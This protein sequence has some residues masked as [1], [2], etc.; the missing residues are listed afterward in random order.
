[1]PKSDVF[2]M[3]CLEAMRAMPDKAFDLAIV[4]P[5]YGINA[6]EMNM[7]SNPTR[8]RNDGHGS[9]PAISTAVKLKGRLN[10]GGG[11][12][13]N[14]LLNTSKFGWD[15]EKPS[16]DYWQELFRISKNQIVFGGNYF[17]EYLPSSRGVGC[18]DKLQPWENFSQW[19][20]IWTSFDCPSFIIRKSNT[21][22]ANSETK[23]HPTQKPVYVYRYLLKKF[24]VPLNSILD[25]HLGSQSSRIAAYQMGFDF[26][27]YEIDTAY[28]NDGNKRFAEATAQASLFP[29]HETKQAS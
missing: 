10:S 5:P 20:M 22:G 19:E 21:G 4:D 8:S 7:G 14:R 1:M 12:L 6:T 26:T 28:F 25:T 15:N 27:G 2:N 9:G 3:D 16:A 11:K 29:F 24:G 23:I 13:K 18:W 17:S